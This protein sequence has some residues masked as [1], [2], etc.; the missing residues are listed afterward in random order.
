MD[1][2][3]PLGGHCGG[4]QANTASP[5]Y[6]AN[7]LSLTSATVIGQAVPM[8]ATPLLSR[9]YSPA[10]VG[11]YSTFS[12]LLAVVIVVSSARYELAIALPDNDNVARRVFVLS[13]SINAVTAVVSLTLGAVVPGVL[14]DLLGLR[15]IGPYLW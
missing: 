13:F 8:L 5:D 3:S 7:V 11:L 6:L 9:L 15:D 10:D 4:K 12:A 14:S 1:G 2:A